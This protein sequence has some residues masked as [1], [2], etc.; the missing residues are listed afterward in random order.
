MTTNNVEQTGDDITS[1]H[2]VLKVECPF[3][4]PDDP[5]G[6]GYTPL[7]D[8]SAGKCFECGHTFDIVVQWHDDTND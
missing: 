1:H 3:C 4:D 5:D 2:G 6:P 8:L 7:V